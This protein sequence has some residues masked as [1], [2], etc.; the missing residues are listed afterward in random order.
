ML[1]PDYSVKE[2]HCALFVWPYLAVWCEN[3]TVTPER[4]RLRCYP[5]LHT[6]RALTTGN[7][8]SGLGSSHQSPPV[9]HHLGRTTDICF[10]NTLVEE[11]I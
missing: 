3:L 5:N 2:L 6:W 1:R 7:A 8:P 4:I 10:K 11:L 9:I